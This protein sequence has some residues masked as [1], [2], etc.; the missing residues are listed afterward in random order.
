M[1]LVEDWTDYNKSLIWDIAAKHFQESGIYSYNLQNTNGIPNLLTNSY[2]HALSF[3]KLIKANLANYPSNKTIQILDIGSGSGMFARFCLI[4]A[5]ELGILERI[6]FLLSDISAIPLKEIKTKGILAEFQGHYKLLQFNVFD[7]SSAKDLEANSYTLENLAAITMNYVYDALPMQPL[8]PK[9]KE[10]Y[11]K[12]QLKLSDSPENHNLTN[13][14]IETRWSDY[15]PDISSDLEKKFI[16]LLDG[17][18]IN[19]KGYIYYNY[20]SLAANENLIKLCD[21]NGF[22]FATDML[23]AKHPQLSFDIYGNVCAHAIN[24]ILLAKSMRSLGHEA[25]IAKDSHLCKMIFTKNPASIKTLQKTLGQEFNQNSN[26]DIFFDLYVAI[27]SVY[28]RYSRHIIRY[29]IQE[30]IKLDPHSHISYAF[31]ARL[32]NLEGQEKLTESLTK[33]AQGLDF[34][35]E[36]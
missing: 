16:K 27:Q 33:K 13:I 34:L 11:E 5:R 28:S 12:L 23:E 29:L 35:G 6:E 4:A 22:I 36:L 26:T 31:Q 24:E 3:I 2:P 9:D 19:S 1:E 30:F 15:N 32:A 14:H 25:Y 7:P 20:G 8:R 18:Q 10:H 21:D 17:E